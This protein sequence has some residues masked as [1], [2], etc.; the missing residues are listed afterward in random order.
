MP[1]CVY[2]GRWAEN[3]ST[4]V[5][6]QWPFVTAFCTLSWVQRGYK[7]TYLPVQ[8]K[9]RAT[10]ASAA[11]AQS[12][13]PEEVKRSCLPNHSPRHCPVSHHGTRGLPARSAG[14]AG[15]HRPRRRADCGRRR[16]PN[17]GGCQLPRLGRI[18]H[19]APPA[20]QRPRRPGGALLLASASR[21]PYSPH[22]RTLITGKC[23]N[24][25]TGAQRPETTLIVGPV[26]S[27]RLDWLAGLTSAAPAG[28]GGTGWPARRA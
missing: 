21:A 9:R 26:L 11:V 4:L 2:A 14:P 22:E 16:G 3:A 5:G 27:G 15:N 20:P 13:R 6:R 19:S 17:V 24:R 28:F 25:G 10:T 12:T 23:S 18:E 7:I 1:T 8:E